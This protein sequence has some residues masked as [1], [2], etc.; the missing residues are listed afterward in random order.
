[1]FC[2]QASRGKQRKYETTLFR[3]KISSHTKLCLYNRC[4][5]SSNIFSSNSLTNNNNTQ[6]QQLRLQTTELC[7]RADPR[8]HPALKKDNKKYHQKHRSKKTVVN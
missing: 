1:M 6:Q 7:I 4:R 3:E 2:K 8:H 5:K